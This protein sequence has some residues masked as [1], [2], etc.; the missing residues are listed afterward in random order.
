MFKIPS[1]ICNSIRFWELIFANSPNLVTSA[2]DDPI[3]AKA[4]AFSSFVVGRTAVL[5]K[6]PPFRNYFVRIHRNRMIG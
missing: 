2:S 1:K 3:N 5:Q 6:A 4:L